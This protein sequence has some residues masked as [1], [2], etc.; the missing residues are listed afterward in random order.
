MTNASKKIFFVLGMHRSGTSAI[1]RA[2]KVFG[3]ELGDS[4]LPPLSGNN[5]KGFWEDRE[6]NALNIRI[7][8]ILGYDWHSLTLLNNRDIEQ[9]IVKGYFIEAA[10]LLKAKCSNGTMFGFKDPRL[11]KLIPFWRKVVRYCGYESTSVLAIRNPISVVKSLEA[12]DGFDTVKGYL[13]WLEHT[14]TALSE[15]NGETRIFIDYDLLMASPEAQLA[16]LSN[17]FKLEIDQDELQEYTSDFLDESLRHSSFKSDDLALDVHCPP[18]VAEVYSCLLEIAADKQL[19]LDCSLQESTRNWLHELHRLNSVLAYIDRLHVQNE[20]TAEVNKSLN[21]QVESFER[22][23][24][25]RDLCVADLRNKLRLSDEEHMKKICVLESRMGELMRTISERDAHLLKLTNVN[26]KLCK[27]VLALDRISSQNEILG[28]TVEMLRK[29][30]DSLIVDRDA[31][32]N[33]IS[34]LEAAREEMRLDYEMKLRNALV[35][36]D[37][38]KVNTVEEFLAFEGRQFIDCVYLRLLKRLPDVNGYNYYLGRLEAGYTKQH[39]LAQIVS[40][41]EAKQYNVVINGMKKELLKYRL[42][43]LPLVGFFLRSIDDDKVSLLYANICHIMNHNEI[44]FLELSYKLVLQRS[45]DQKGLEFYL[46]QLA[47][48][49]D[50]LSVIE[51]LVESQ[52]A[53]AIKLDLQV[54]KYALRRYKQSQLPLVRRSYS[55]KD[56]SRSADIQVATQASREGANV[57]SILLVSY[58]CPTRAHAGGLRILDIYKLIRDSAPQTRLDLF[59]YRR[60]DIDWDYSDIEQI[61]DNIYCSDTEEL[62]LNS[63]LLK[64]SPLPVYDIID[65]QF[66]QS[67][68][69][70]DDFKRVG[71]RILFTPME[72]LAK[73]CLIDLREYLSKPCF[74]GLTEDAINRLSAIVLSEFAA[75]PLDSGNITVRQLASRV[76]HNLAQKLETDKYGKILSDFFNSKIT[77]VEE[78]IFCMK[79]DNTVCVSKT[80]ASLLRY[81]T[82]LSNICAVETAISN[83]EFNDAFT[84]L[85]SLIKP[86][87]KNNHILYVAYF[88]SETNV[89]AL[90]WFLD[91]VHPHIRERVK[92]YKLLVVGRGDLS[93]F[94]AYEAVDL[95]GEVLSIAPHIRNAKVGIAP[96][97]GGAGFRGKVNQYAIYGVPCVASS[98]AAN[99]LAYQDGINICI[100]DD[101]SAFADRCVKLLVDN[102]Y[103]KNIGTLARE[104]ALAKYSWQ[105]KRNRLAKLYKLSDV[106]AKSGEVLQLMSLPPSDYALSCADIDKFKQTNTKPKVTVLVPSFNHGKYIGKRIESIFAQTYENFELIVIDDCSEDNSDELILALQATYGFNYMRNAKNS[107]T[108]FAAWEK[109]ASIASGDFIWICESDDFAHPS[110]LETTV[111]A[112]LDNPGAVIA[113]CDSVIVDEQDKAVDHTETYFHEI[114]RETRWDSCFVN[115]GI[116][117]LVRYQVRGQTVPNMSSA[118]ISS[119]AFKAAFQ[120]IIKKFKLTGDWLFVGWLMSFGGVAFCKQALNHFRRHEVTSRVRVKSAQSQA[121]FVLTKYL[122][123]KESA[124]P[125]SA[126]AVL[127]SSDLIRFLYEPASLTEVVRAMFRISVLKSLQL[128]LKLGASLVQNPPVATEFYRRYQTVRRGCDAN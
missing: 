15:T 82:G 6:F 26:E 70:I 11:A 89:I 13:L 87:S 63:F 19:P 86:E 51:Q 116:D 37:Y 25:E 73:A 71:N 90:K 47:S 38:A 5:E 121:E 34:I 42:S 45:P 115:T 95:V 33:G 111:N 104:R 31:W 36:S 107:G 126:F 97:L 41:P 119:T 93:S 56:Q 52:E 117:E 40:S 29:T 98:I 84:N 102:Q 30:V 57:Y 23:V 78:L 108:P 114:W 49:K 61:F 16:R 123:F 94:A 96:A 22:S 77:A 28:N 65:L 43:F 62:T 67:A 44:S 66:H 79:S 55:Q 76:L 14:L 1:T 10:D 54:L 105:A 53:K 74:I 106:S 7:L 103:N 80:D 100:A 113:Y 32:K 59:T 120:P 18:L 60:P 75:I 85:D 8:K 58:Y 12:R 83:I 24:M 17:F 88:G 35:Y 21:A 50:K 46:S 81:V 39:V 9:L 110:F 125:L 3:I 4:L 64:C 92:D 127:M 20:R 91:N 2:L 48:G 101:P 128:G 99:G 118:L 122:L 109:I 112:M 68:E 69:H 27:K 124:Q 72:S